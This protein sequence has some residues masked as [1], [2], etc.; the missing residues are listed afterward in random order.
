MRNCYVLILLL[1]INFSCNPSNSNLPAVAFL[2]FIEDP[3][4]QLARKGFFEALDQNGF[5]EEENTIRVYYA[6]A[7]GDIPTLGQS[8][9]Y[10]LSQKPDLLATNVTLS[11]ITAVNKTGKVPI[12][13]MVSPRP[14]IAGLSSVDNTYPP[15]LFGVYETL[16]YIDSSVMIIKTIHSQLK[17]MGTLYNQAE[18]QSRIA[19]ERLE[20]QAQKEGIQIIPMPVSNSSETQLVVQSLLQQKPDAFFALPDNVI[21]ASFESIVQECRK[22]KIP[23]FT[24]EAG[25]V[26]RGAIASYGADFYEWGFQSGLQAA[27]Y[28]K[29]KHTR[30]LKPELVKIRK[31][32]MNKVLCK[33]Y[34]LICN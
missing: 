24:S 19:L 1:G 27:Q 7:H 20:Q 10:L 26:E 34:N 25:L 18:P 31:L 32:K 11:T 30:N 12:F 22:Q 2:D 33:E 13:M 29:E 4:V 23:I 17:T 28:L 21:F 14:D 15:N 9:D 3:T 8:C 16:E 5:S 6:N